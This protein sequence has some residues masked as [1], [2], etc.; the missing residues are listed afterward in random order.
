MP[1]A[2]LLRAF[3]YTCAFAGAGWF[4]DWIYSVVSQPGGGWDSSF[5]VIII[6]S[7]AAGVIVAVAIMR[8]DRN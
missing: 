5:T 6:T 7:V 3:V 1:L 2:L 4:G 8:F